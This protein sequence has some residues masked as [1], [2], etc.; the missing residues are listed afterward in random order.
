VW[1]HGVVIRSPCL[2]DPSRRSPRWEQVFVQALVARAT[3]K[4]F[5]EAVLL[6]LARR[7]VIPFDPGVLASGEDGVT[8]QL[9]AVVADH[10]AR[11]SATLHDSTQ[12]AN[13]PLAR[14]RGVDDAS[15]A[16]PAVVVNDVEHAGPPAAGQ[17]IQH[18]V[19]RPALVGLLRERHR[20]SRLQRALAAATLAYR[21]PPFGYRR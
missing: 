1:T 2:V 18:E 11:Q 6:R 21:Q 20:R 15:Q 4:A 13:D 10:H 3:I 8:G 14:Q 17:C 12:L 7:D 19:Q 9:N 5:D 16:F